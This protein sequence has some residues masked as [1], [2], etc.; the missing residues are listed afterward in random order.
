MQLSIIIPVYNAVKTLGR[1]L[2]SILSQDICDYEVILIDD[3]SKDSSYQL[4]QDYSERYPFITCYQNSENIGQGLTRNRGIE[5]ARGQYL[6][7]VDSDDY[8]DSHMYSDLLKLSNGDRDVVKCGLT[9]VTS[10]SC[11]VSELER[12][13]G[14]FAANSYSE[15]Q[16]SAYASLIGELPGNVDPFKTDGSACSGIYKAS[17]IR[18]NS[19]KFPSERIIYSEDLFF[20]LDALRTAES[21]V[22]TT[23]NYYFYV[24]NPVS[25]S[26]AYHDPSTK[27]KKILSY[28][29]NDA[30]LIHRASQ[31]IIDDIK[32]AAMQL[33]VD[34]SYSLSEKIRI[35][36]TLEQSNFFRDAISLCDF[37]SMN[38]IDKI[39]FSLSKNAFGMPELALANINQIIR[40]KRHGL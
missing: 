4:C 5:H 18:E 26:H 24:K 13:K 2:S 1:C 34:N 28:A 33:V 22:G 10:A 19:I 11:R 27:C 32:I 15:V 38:T 21:F 16:E 36:R 9:K 14:V 37:N 12:L 35:L 20:N 7:F 17:L 40:G 31:S 39:F 3:C 25:T 6:G 23:T 8:I 30:A 29:G